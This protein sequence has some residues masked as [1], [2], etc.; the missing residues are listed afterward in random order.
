MDA[1][2]DVLIVGGG[3][4]GALLALELR[5]R[6]AAVTLLDAPP[7][8]GSHS[9]TAISYGAIPGWP[10]AA[11]PLARLAAGAGRRWRQ[12]QRRHGPLGWQPRALRLQGANRTLAGLSR[13][14]VLP[15]A[16]V[17]T[18]VLCDRLPQA[19]SAAGVTCRHTPVLSL[20]PGQQGWSVHGGDGTRSSAPQLVL[21][22]GAGCLE[23]WSPLPERL[24]T[25]WA[26]VLELPAFPPDL[27]P[28]AAWLPQGFSR[29]GLERQAAQLQQPSWVVDAALVPW[30]TGALLGQHTWIAPGPRAGAAP[31]AELCERQLRQALAGTTPW[32]G[33]RGQ[34]RQAAVAFCSG[35]GPLVGPAP[36]APPGL[37]IFSGFSGAFAQ[38]PVLAPLLAQHLLGPAAEAAEAKH[39]LKQLGVWP[40]EG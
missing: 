31:G 26:S 20:T 34:L 35:G 19:L 25:S 12:L 17:D 7:A 30:G 18:A 8:D 39:R 40:I 28:A 37:W 24:R 2:A 16:Q 29:L 9:A 23:L 33:L 21:A 32:A 10:L 11:T 4:A 1:A 22:A 6:G 13:C 14:G 36:Q 38:V 15:F 5:V 3:L 27:G